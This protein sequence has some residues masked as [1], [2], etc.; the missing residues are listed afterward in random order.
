VNTIRLGVVAVTIVL[1][2]VASAGHVV[3]QPET[4]TAFG[5]GTAPCGAWTDHLSDKAAHAGDLQWVLGFASAA[6]VFA[7]VQL[8]SNPGTFEPFMAKYCQDHPSDTITTA[9]A[10]LVGNLR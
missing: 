4:F 10:N 2:L 6:G 7:G 8:K 9:A 3:A 5:A 1:V